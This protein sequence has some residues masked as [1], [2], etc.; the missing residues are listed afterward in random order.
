MRADLHL[1]TTASDGSW[2]VE[3]LIEEL[4]KENIGLFSVTD[5]DS[6]DNVAAAGRLAAAAGLS[7]LPGVEI[8][9]TLSGQSFHILGYGIKPQTESLLALLRHNTG[10]LEEVDHDCIRALI[11]D[12]FPLDYDE[13]AAYRHDP[14]R[15]GW[16]ALNFLVD[17]EICRSAAEFFS[18]VFTEERG[19]RFPE[20]PEPA[21]VIAVIREAGG[22]PVLAHPGS[23][24][25][26]NSLEETLDHFAREEIAGIECYHPGH[27][28]VTTQRALAWCRRHGL[29]ITGGSDC[30]GS[31][32]PERRLGQPYIVMDDLFL[33]NLITE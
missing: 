8:C 18:V 1:H 16:K 17:K 14:H 28:A 3:K 32:L 11:K 2:P 9:S 12:G 31:F 21:K 13:Y 30:H 6:V 5:H 20:F 15:G 27:D 19:L 26:G 23:G 7:F 33:G 25:H 10:L 24:F 29:L 4:K 22:L